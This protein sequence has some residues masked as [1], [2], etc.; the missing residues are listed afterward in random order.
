MFL[1]NY[2]T[3]DPGAFATEK[4]PEPSQTDP[5]PTIVLPGKST[6]PKKAMTLTDMMRAKN[7]NPNF[8]IDFGK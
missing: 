8:V 2:Q 1:Q 5:A 4:A 3:N 7:Q 6:P